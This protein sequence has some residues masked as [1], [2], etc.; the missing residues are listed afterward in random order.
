MIVPTAATRWR[1][2]LARWAIP[3]QILERAPESPWHF[4]VKLFA[5]RADSVQGTAPT[6]SNLR[7]LEALPKGG[8]VLDV[9]CGAGAASLALT[10]LASTLLGVDTSGEML[11]AFV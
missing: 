3:D 11:E 5:S 4:P 2:D 6:P 7:A 9:G 1:E 10:S 8:S